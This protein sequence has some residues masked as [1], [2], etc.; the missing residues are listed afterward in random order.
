ALAARSSASASLAG[1]AS[2]GSRSSAWSD[3]SED[4]SDGLSP[5]SITPSEAFAFFRGFLRSAA[6]DLVTILHA[7]TR[8]WSLAPTS[9]HPIIGGYAKP[10][11]PGPGGRRRC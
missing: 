9:L 7:T 1:S 11:E 6:I 2:A 8:R 10:V 4:L 5:T 3:S